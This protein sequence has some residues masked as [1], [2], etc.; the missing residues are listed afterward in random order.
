[1]N[2]SQPTSWITPFSDEF[3]QSPCGVVLSFP[4]CLGLHL[5]PTNQSFSKLITT[6]C[7]QKEH[8]LF[9]AFTIVQV[10]AAS[11]LYLILFPVSPLCLIFPVHF[12]TLTSSINSIQFSSVYLYSA[13]LQ[14]LSSQGIEEETLQVSG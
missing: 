6:L 3:G 9:P 13:K 14:Q 1:M 7:V 8:V 5:T 10:N 2:E 12:F 11:F 4:F